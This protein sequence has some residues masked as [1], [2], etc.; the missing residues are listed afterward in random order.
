MNCFLTEYNWDIE[1]LN[2][3]RLELLPSNPAT[4]WS[5]K[6]VISIDDTLLHKT[7]KQMPGAGKLFDHTEGHY[8]ACPEYCNKQLCG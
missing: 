4:R 2:N 6:G 1:E 7:G 8:R 5:R 3:K